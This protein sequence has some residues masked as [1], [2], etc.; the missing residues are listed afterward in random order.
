[1]HVSQWW[2]FIA[3]GS[4]GSSCLCA[5]AMLLHVVRFPQRK[6]RAML[7]GFPTAYPV[8]A[9]PIHARLKEAM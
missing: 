8:N 9:W 3:L 7:G 2:H 1:M 6:G 5:A 4:L